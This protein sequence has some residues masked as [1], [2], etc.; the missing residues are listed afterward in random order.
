[1]KTFFATILAT[2]LVVLPATSVAAENRP[3]WPAWQVTANVCDY[4]V[5][6]TYASGIGDFMVPI[7]AMPPAAGSIDPVTL[8]LIATCKSLKDRAAQFGCNTND[9]PPAPHFP[10][11]TRGAWQANGCG[12]GNWF[13][14]IGSH[15]IAPDVDGY[16]GSLDEPLTDIS[17]KSAC[18]NHDQCYYTGFKSVCDD[19]FAREL[20]NVCSAARGA[21]GCMII[22][23]RYTTAVNDVGEWA[24]S[25]D[26]MVMECA[27][28]SNT[29]KDGDCVQ[30]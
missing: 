6:C 30:S 28:I 13:D 17:F 19:A 5:S 18:D 27:R 2:L 22:A 8:E 10:S 12:I 4:V 9:P 3:L 25:H 15:I 21:T 14:T 24:Y 23:G 11:P 7:R 16:T 29:L 1:M 26:H 20:A